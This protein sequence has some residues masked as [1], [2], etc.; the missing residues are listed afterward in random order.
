MTKNAKFCQIW[1]TCRDKV[2]AD[3]I[4]NA[5]LAK[6]L[7]TCYGELSPYIGKFWW[8]DKIE[9]NDEILLEMLSRLDLF[10]EIEAEV[11]KLHSYDTFVLEATSV[12]RISKKAT[13]WLKSELKNV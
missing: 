13:A 3:K 12:T 10:D 11:A 2:E 4:A 1:L 9:D 7:I 5:L 8:Q 6:R